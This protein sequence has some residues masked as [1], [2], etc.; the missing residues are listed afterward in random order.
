[1]T[2]DG[3]VILNSADASDFD[4]LPGVGKKRAEQIVQLRTKLGGRFKKPSDLLRI[5]GIGVKSLQKM[6]PHLVLD[7]PSP[8]APIP[9]EPR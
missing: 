4:R 9:E 2:A 8:Q 7:P 5:R 6:L 3:K 1:M